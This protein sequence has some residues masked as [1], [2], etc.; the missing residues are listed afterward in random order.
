VTMK[1]ESSRI[2]DPPWDALTRPS[3]AELLRRSRQDVGAFGEFYDRHVGDLIAYFQR[4]VACPQTAADLTAETFAAAFL[5][6]DRFRDDGTPARAWLFTIGHRKYVGFVRSRS[7]ADRASRKIGL[8][9][10]ELEPA[11]VEDIEN[12]L[13][14]AAF[15]ETAMGALAG[16]PRRLRHA[17]Y[18]RVCMDLPYVEVAKELGCSEAAARVRVSRGLGRIAATVEDQHGE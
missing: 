5:G 3:D 7:V 4:R 14:R 15:A 8:E 11:E 17:V 2:T 13:D 16:L 6:R 10:H 9:R 12:R 18:L 1:S